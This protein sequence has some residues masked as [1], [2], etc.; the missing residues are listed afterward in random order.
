MR[1]YA[2]AFGSQWLAYQRTQL[3][4]FT[5]TTISRE[6]LERCLGAP[7]ASVH[8]R[9]V[10][11]V[12]CGAGRFTEWLVAAGARLVAMDASTAVAANR[13]NCAHLGHYVLLS[14]DINA[15]PLRPASFDVVLCLGVIQHTPSPERTIADLAQHVAPG[16]TL[17]IDHYRFVS[18]LRHVGEQVLTLKLPLRALFRRV[19]RRRPALALRLTRAVTAVCDPIRRRT[20]RHRWLERLAC[21]LFPSACYYQAFPGLPPDVLYAWNELDTHDRLTDWYKHFRS[22]EHIRAALEAAGLRDIECWSG[23][24]GVEAR[25]ARS[26]LVS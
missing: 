22:V 16:G 17:V 13:A 24:N 3:D 12:G 18:R 14:A 26:P 19:A 15:S 5:G 21:R 9:R 10:L 6:R 23:G 4:S 2:S 25:A 11:E 1:H 20:S 7:V 8:G